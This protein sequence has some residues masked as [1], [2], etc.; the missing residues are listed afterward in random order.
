MV[1]ESLLL[2]AILML[3]TLLFILFFGD[4]TA[5]PKRYFLQVFLWLVCGTYFVWNWSRGGQTLA[6]QTWRI[7]LITQSGKQLTLLQAVKRYLVASLFFGAGFVW[8]FFDRDGLFLHDRLC[9]SKLVLLDK[10]L[11]D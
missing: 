9:G 6:M 8:A 2:M 5:A 10:P 11:K 1:Y 3:A 4:A 7:K